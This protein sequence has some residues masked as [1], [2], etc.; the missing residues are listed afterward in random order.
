M[1]LIKTLRKPYL[2]IFL[3][4]LVLFV[5]CS[6]DDNDSVQKF[7]DA[8]LKLAKS[9]L[10]NLTFTANIGSDV[11]MNHQ[12]MDYFQSQN[13]INIE[14]SN[15]LY[16]LNEK[17]TNEKVEIALETGVLNQED[18]TLIVNLENNLKND[19][20]DNVIYNFEESILNL[21]LSNEKFEI[22]N[23]FV[24]A[25]KLTNSTDSSLF[26]SN[27]YSA[28]SLDF[29]CALATIAFAAA[30]VGL[31]TLEVGTAGLATAGVVVGYIAASTALVRACKKQ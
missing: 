1:N 6:Q 4:S 10:D 5:S 30:A 28:K 22:Y 3:A 12:L 17:T 19:N 16:E 8:S 27:D 23:T 18:L 11:D 21:N 2:S 13:N 20:F 29:D 14:F 9:Q 7:D 24:N 26:Q 31:A 15:A 25:L